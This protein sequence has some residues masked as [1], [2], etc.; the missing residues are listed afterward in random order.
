MYHVTSILN[1]IIDSC[2]KCPILSDEELKQFCPFGTEEPKNNGPELITLDEDGNNYYSALFSHYGANL[3]SDRFCNERGVY[4]DMPPILKSIPRSDAKRYVRASDT[5]PFGRYKKLESPYD[6]WCKDN[7]WLL[8]FKIKNTINDKIVIDNLYH[9]DYTNAKEYLRDYFIDEF[10]S[11]PANISL[12]PNDIKEF[13]EFMTRLKKYSR[14]TDADL[15]PSEKEMVRIWGNVLSDIR[16][17]IVFKDSCWVKLLSERLLGAKGFYDSLETCSE[18][19]A[20]VL[21]KGHTISVGEQLSL[22]TLWH[23]LRD[24]NYGHTAM[25]LICE[26]G[27]RIKQSLAMLGSIISLFDTSILNNGL[28]IL[29]GSPHWSERF[30]MSEAQWL[31]W[32]LEYKH[33]EGCNDCP[34]LI[35]FSSF[36]TSKGYKSF[37]KESIAQIPQKY[38]AYFLD[39]TIIC[40]PHQIINVSGAEANENGIIVIDRDHLVLLLSYLG[41]HTLDEL[42]EGEDNFEEIIVRDSYDAFVPSDI[43]EVD[44]LLTEEFV[45]QLS[46][47]LSTYS[48]MTEEELSKP[49]VE[50]VGKYLGT[51]RENWFEHLIKDARR[52]LELM[53]LNQIDY[54][55]EEKEIQERNKENYELREKIRAIA[56]NS[57][58]KRRSYNSDF[59]GLEIAKEYGDGNRLYL[60]NAAAFIEALVDKGVLNPDNEKNMRWNIYSDIFVDENGK[61]VPPKTFSKRFS[62]YKRRR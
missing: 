3:M 60:L 56:L 40:T 52:F 62:E 36:L 39:P 57:F 24:D 19:M 51:I 20:N 33:I 26:E 42:N 45:C 12:K 11:I 14:D 31:D 38:R 37:S 49:W 25:S 10:S 22:F 34:P 35:G 30:F 5:E 1:H 2:L 23:Y 59:D 44:E 7:M 29:E 18:L 43:P 16:A 21:S 55:I 54:S 27:E 15:S 32:I 13:Y 46:V 17:S 47:N 9:H 28:T 53:P 61:P 50:T 41:C 6:P 48:M 8:Q 4:N 58:G